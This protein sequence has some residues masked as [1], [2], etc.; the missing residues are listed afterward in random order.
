MQSQEAITQVNSFVRSVYNWMAAGLA[1]TGVV[2]YLFAPVMN[3]GG[4]E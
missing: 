3:A 2:A 1:I 4:R